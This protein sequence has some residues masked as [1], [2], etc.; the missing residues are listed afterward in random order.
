MMAQGR[1]VKGSK[2]RGYT[3]RTS[4]SRLASALTLTLKPKRPCSSGLI[5]IRT[6]LSC[7]TTPFSCNSKVKSVSHGAV[8][9]RL[10][11]WGNRNQWLQITWAIKFASKG[12]NQVLGQKKKTNQP[13]EA[14]KKTKK[15]NKYTLPIQQTQTNTSIYLSAGLIFSLP[16][17]LHLTSCTV[18]EKIS[19]SRFVYWKWLAAYRGLKTTKLKP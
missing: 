14:Y 6:R 16:F 10:L 18:Q 19:G 2:E 9:H 12:Q 15:T 4:A 11:S 5:L 7:G 8:F 17:A 13:K 1:E 3:K